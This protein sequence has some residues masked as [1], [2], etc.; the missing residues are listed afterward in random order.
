MNKTT[1]ALG[2]IFNA[3]FTQVL[4]I[5]KNRPAWQKGK[6]NGVGGHVEKNESYMEAI[7]REVLEETSLISNN[8]TYTCSL[9]GN[10]WHTRIFATQYNRKL[11]DAKTQTDEKVRWFHVNKLPENI[12]SNLPWLIPLCIDKIKNKEIKNCRVSY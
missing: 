4:L 5:Q 10:D 3:S 1:Y 9:D 11:D 7:K 8:W 2:F 6:Y 12:I